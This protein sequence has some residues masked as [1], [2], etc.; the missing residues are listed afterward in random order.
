MSDNLQEIERPQIVKSFPKK[1]LY[2]LTFTGLFAV[3]LIGTGI[4]LYIVGN[5][6]ASYNGDTIAVNKMAIAAVAL[7]VVVVIFVINT[8]VAVRFHRYK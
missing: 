1:I 3:P 5:F 6:F 7:L 8:K 2:Y 4:L